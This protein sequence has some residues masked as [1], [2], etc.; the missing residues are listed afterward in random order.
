MTD[1]VI[2]SSVE[3]VQATTPETVETPH[4][5]TE[6]QPEESTQA[7]ERKFSQDE[8]NAIIQKE[9]AKAEARAERRALKVYAD[10]LEAMSQK[11]AE[12]KEAPK[13]GKP[14]MAQFAN[15]ED[16]VEAVADW[17]LEQREQ[18]TKQKQAEVAQKSVYERTEGIYAQ[19]QKI[20]G[21]DRESF[22]ELPLTPTVAQAIIESDE[23]PRLMAYLV[24]NPKEAERIA[25]LSPARQA[26][27]LGKIE[28]KFPSAVKDVAVSKAPAPIK[29]I[30]SHGS[31]SKTPEQMTD[32]EFAD[33]RKKQIAARR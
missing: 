9:K 32:K 26:A 30:G 20:A 24:N 19:A 15:V 10:R 25:T 31:A 4:D 23:A 33:W 17:K 2:E 8:L 22:D 13:D 6:A 27:E 1:E 29:P 7:D 18:G 28:A 5:A 12:T 3:E 21:F 14:I 16:Y 11:P